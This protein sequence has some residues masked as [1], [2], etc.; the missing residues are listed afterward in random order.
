VEKA[1]GS[2]KRKVILISKKS[3]EQSQI[4]AV[5]SKNDYELHLIE[6]IENLDIYLTDLSSNCV[7]FDLDSV[8]IDN[9]TI[10]EL[11]IQYPHIYF[12]CLS[13]DRFHPELKDAICYHIFACLTKP[14]DYDELI[15]WLRCIDIEMDSNSLNKNEKKS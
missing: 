11:T 1:S 14:L 7:I 8:N 9:R 3:K 4:D 2:M 10:R 5:L 12:L 15:Y 6:S 13:K